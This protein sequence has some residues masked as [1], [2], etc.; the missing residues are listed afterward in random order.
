MSINNFHIIDE[1]IV[2]IIGS[3][4][5]DTSSI[6]YVWVYNI[7]KSYTMNWM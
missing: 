3:H 5:K 1:E 4:L 2:V 7:D 6:T